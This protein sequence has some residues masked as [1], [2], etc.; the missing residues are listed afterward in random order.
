VG[1]GN[2]PPIK[3]PTVAP[4]IPLPESPQPLAV[5]EPEHVRSAEP[6]LR[7]YFRPK[8]VFATTVIGLFAAAIWLGITVVFP[9]AGALLSRFF[10]L[11]STVLRDA[12]YRAAASDPTSDPALFLMQAAVWAVVGFMLNTVSSL[13]ISYL[14]SA[15]EF[16]RLLLEAAE[17]AIPKPAPIPVL[18]ETPLTTTEV[19]KRRIRESA[20]RLES[21]KIRLAEQSARFEKG[22]RGKRHWIIALTLSASLTV[23]S[24]F[25][26]Y[27]MSTRSISIWREFHTNVRICAPYMDPKDI[28]LL[29]SRYGQM[30]TRTEYIAIN[31][32]LKTVADRNSL[33][34]HDFAW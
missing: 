20:A 15:V 11:G 13:F 19:L 31:A 30:G 8:A 21:S 16:K 2:V 18:E 14:E 17:I 9:M 24:L 27:V 29:E 28:A 6:P 33:K 34:L 23:F 22:Q 7:D 10:T 32:E 12:P 26:L 5:T 4:S 25:M 1:T 3:L